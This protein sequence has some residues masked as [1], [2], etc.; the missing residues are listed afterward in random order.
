MLSDAKSR[1]NS[2][3]T[4]LDKSSGGEGK[5][6]EAPSLTARG[7]AVVA[8]DLARYRTWT[9]LV[10]TLDA[11]LDLSVGVTAGFDSLKNLDNSRCFFSALSGDSDASYCL[12]PT[13]RPELRLCTPSPSQFVGLCEGTTRLCGRLLTPD[14]VCR[15]SG[16]LLSCSLASLTIRELDTLFM[17]KLVG[18]MSFNG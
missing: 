3:S 10:A 9:G 16:L 8:T 12:L 15:K 1:S 5:L 18:E 7:R 4:S 2:S 17:I 13:T 14:T 11:E 6:K